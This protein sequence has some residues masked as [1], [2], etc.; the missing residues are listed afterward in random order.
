MPGL[1]GS[2][3]PE[4]KC[5]SSVWAQA[6]LR[7]L[8]LSVPPAGGGVWS[9]SGAIRS[10]SGTRFLAAARS[11]AQTDPHC[12]S[13]ESSEGS[14]GGAGGC[15]ARG[16]VGA[17]QRGVQ[18]AAAPQ[19]PSQSPRR[20]LA[21]QGVE[22]GGGGAGPGAHWVRRHPAAPLLIS[23]LSFARPTCTGD[24]PGTRPSPTQRRGRGRGAPAPTSR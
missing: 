19:T 22:A 15:K 10:L 7:P 16:L 14:E 20:A 5:T 8:H 12:A 11:R 3:R 13:S 2:R 4:C 6:R 24:P 9:E 18:R 21:G 1:P 17:V 23:S